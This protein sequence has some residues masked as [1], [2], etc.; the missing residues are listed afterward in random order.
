LIHA[1]EGDGYLRQPEGCRDHWFD[2]QD[3]SSGGLLRPSVG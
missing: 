2:V 1:G 3:F